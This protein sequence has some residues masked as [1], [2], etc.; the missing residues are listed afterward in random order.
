MTEDILILE[1]RLSIGNKW[2]EIIKEMPGRTENNVKNRFNMM[3]KNIKD[4]FIKNRNHQSVFAMQE[5]CVQD[6]SQVEDQLDEEKLIRQLIEKKKREREERR[7]QLAPGQAGPSQ[8]G[9][10]PY[11]ETM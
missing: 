3:Y 2:S 4:E 7:N 6:A 5:T 11:G 1:K 9:G 10:T 8:G